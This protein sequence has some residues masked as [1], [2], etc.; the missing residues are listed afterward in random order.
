MLK[1]HNVVQGEYL[2]PGIAEEGEEALRGE[3]C[4]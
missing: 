1:V 3:R 4:A 2:R